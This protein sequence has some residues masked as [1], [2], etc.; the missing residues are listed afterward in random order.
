MSR[1]ELKI[2]AKQALETWETRW[3]EI[4]SWNPSE[5]PQGKQDE[6]VDLAMHSSAEIRDALEYLIHYMDDVENRH[7]T[8]AIDLIELREDLAGGLRE[9][10]NYR[11]SISAYSKEALFEEVGDLDA[12][13]D[14]NLLF[15][16]DEVVTGNPLENIADK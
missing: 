6:F 16:D 10:L 7:E 2:A 11:N 14:V 3:T 15:V 12:L 8:S 4:C 9:T 5:T 1:K 13:V